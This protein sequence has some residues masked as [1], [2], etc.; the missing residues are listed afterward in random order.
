V[1]VGYFRRWL[2][3][4]VVTDNLAQSQSDFGS[5]YVVAPQDPRLPNGGGYTV[6]NL[7]NANQNVASLNNNLVT[8]AGNYGNQYNHYNGVLLNVS[9]RPLKGLVFQGGLNTGRTVADACEIRAKIDEYNGQS[10]VWGNAGT[11]GLP[12]TTTF[13]T[14][15]AT[16]PWCHVDTGFITRWTGLGSWTIPKIDVQVAGTLRS[17]QGGAL[18]A[19]YSVPNSVIQPILGRPLSNNA[20]SVTVNLIQPGTLYGDRVNEVD[21]RFAKILRIGVTRTNVGVD[22]YNIINSAAVLTYNQNYNPAT[23]TWLTPTSVLTPRFFKVS[24]TID[25]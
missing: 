22:I 25:F 6:S 8:L 18:G 15:N 2:N 5:F 19:L 23:T 10:T 14:I 20:P 1:E 3:N 9:A 24:A 4:F 11:A 16:N 13:T 7:Y 12:G 17:D 21:L